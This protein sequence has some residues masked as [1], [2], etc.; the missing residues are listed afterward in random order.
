MYRKVYITG[1]I[2][3]WK[4]RHKISM[5]MHIFFTVCSLVEREGCR[6]TELMGV[7]LSV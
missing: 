7:L 6:F 5:G 2:K 4:T 1:S 3:M